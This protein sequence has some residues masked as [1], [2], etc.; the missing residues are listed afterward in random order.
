MTPCMHG[1]HIASPKNYDDDAM[2]FYYAALQSLEC[3]RGAFVV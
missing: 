2:E 1:L 3:E